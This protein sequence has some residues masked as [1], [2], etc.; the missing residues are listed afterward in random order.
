MIKIHHFLSATTFRAGDIY[1]GIGPSSP[2]YPKFEH[3]I[4]IIP[5][6]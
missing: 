6:I 1:H 2:K 5:S 4:S 3:P